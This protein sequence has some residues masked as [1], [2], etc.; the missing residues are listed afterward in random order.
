MAIKVRSGNEWVP[1]S[2]GGGEAIGVVVSW[3]GSASSIPAGYLL[4]DGSAVSRTT[5]SGLFAA[6]GTTNGAGDGSSTFNLPNLVDKFVLGAS[7]SNGDTTY[8]G[9]SP[10]ATGGS[11][12]AVLIAHNHTYIDQYVVINNNYR[13]W[14]ASN[15]DCAQRN[16]NTGT[17]GID[18]DGN[19]DNSQTGTNANLPPYYAL[20]Y[21]IKVFDAR[22]S[23]V[24]TG[25]VG[26][27]GAPGGS[28]NYGNFKKVSLTENINQNGFANRLVIRFD[29]EVFK[30]SIYTHSN[31]TNPGRVTVTAAG[32]YDISATINYDNQGANRISPRASLFKNGTEIT[33]TRA[34][35]YSRGSGYGDEKAL[36]IKTT[37]QLAINDYLE[38][39]AWADQRDQTSAANTIVGECEFIITR[40]TQAAA[41]PGPIG[42][43]GPTG[44]TGPTGPTGPTGAV[45]GPFPQGTVQ[46]FYQAAAPTGWT[47]STTHNNK[48]LRVVSGD[49]GGSGGSQNWTSIFSNT[50]LTEN[51]S[52]TIAQMPEHF[53]QIFNASNSAGSHPNQSNINA[54]SY[55][56]RGT[57]AVNHNEGYNMRSAGSSATRGKTSDRGS[58]SGHRHEI[59]LGL[60]YVDV[61]IAAKD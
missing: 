47:K 34:S 28:L 33:E 14:P 3:S 7:N 26:P 42:P 39:Y 50:K 13:P 60:A 40:L 23:N 1:V 61:I 27:T 57:G 2:G 52:L 36:Q 9:V 35:S 58:G 55:V 25:P 12:N 59:D 8:P 49:G 54:N 29:S 43:T 20:C 18:A 11:A 31:S 16:I 15:N 51:H 37:L 46:L 6:I 45:G 19:S 10:A 4:C 5:Y 22:S 41:V 17:T 30:D 48:G 21:I 56:A 38:I 53:H 44:S 24:T 32:F